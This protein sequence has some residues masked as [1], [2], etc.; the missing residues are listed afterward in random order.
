MSRPRRR[1]LTPLEAADYLS[2]TT[3]T[4]R[5]MVTRG[6]LRAHKCGPR[7]VR[8]DIED[9]DQLM[10]PISSANVGAS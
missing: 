7:L 8:F 1:W 3:R 6:D 5:N 10:V 2:V 4:L 9:L